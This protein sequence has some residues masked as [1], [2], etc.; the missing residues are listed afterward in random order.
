MIFRNL[1]ENIMAKDNVKHTG[2]ITD[3]QLLNLC[4]RV[5]LIL[6]LKQLD[7][8]LYEIKYYISAK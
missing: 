5:L 7:L 4:N 8:S 3:L 1:G 2:E 6:E